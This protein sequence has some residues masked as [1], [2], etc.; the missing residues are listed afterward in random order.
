MTQAMATPRPADLSALATPSLLL[1]AA[2]MDANIRG[3]GERLE[4]LGVRLRPHVKTHKSH[5]VAD[6]VAALSRTSG[7]TVSTLKELHHFVEHGARDV[8]YA[9]GIVP[10]KLDAVAAAMDKGARVSVV[11]DNPETARAVA[12][13][14]RELSRAFEVFL[15]IDTDG[16]RAGLKPD[17]RDLIETARLLQT[18]GARLA[19]VMTHAGE[20]YNCPSVDAIESMAEQERQLCVA[21]ADNLR[22]AGLACP[23]VSVGSTPTATFAERLDGVT[24]VRAGVYVF[25]DLVMAG[26]G[27]CAADDIAMSVLVSVIGHQT[28]RSWLIIDAGW[29]A[30]SRDRGTADQD[31]DQGYGLV[32]DH[33][34]R[35][36]DDLVVISANQ[37]HGI[38]ADRN[39]KPFDV[40]RFPIG[41]KL[42]IL[43]N[44][45][46]ATGAQHDSYAV[47]EDGLNVAMWPRIRGW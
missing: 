38:V 39:G 46:C 17:S 4:R 19:G 44:H 13:R 30:M 37:E 20:S 32:A 23:D 8:M 35:V 45:A 14:G 18:Q 43:P 10:Q 2:K 1:D 24:E 36:L 27:V 15:E 21:A 31:V 25:Q 7:I 33:D 29:M 28:D 16:H 3:M 11:L 42:R 41:S 26:L 6:R 5:E 34:G 9:V 40:D 22:A 12:E 47:I